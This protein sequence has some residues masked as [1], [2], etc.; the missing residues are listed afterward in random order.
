MVIPWSCKSPGGT[1]HYTITAH[2]NV[3]KTLTKSGHFSPVGVE[4]CREYEAKETEA[5]EHHEREVI[6]GYEQEAREERERRER[7]EN[8]C[9]KLG[10]E[11]VVLEVGQEYRIYCRAPG[12]GTIPVPY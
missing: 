6:A 4:R 12:G 11:P 3:G 5:R 2:S 9:R 1:Y 10:G 8:N 7:Y